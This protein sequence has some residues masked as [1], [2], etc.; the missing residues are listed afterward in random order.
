V[1]ILEKM[2]GIMLAAITV[3][4]LLGQVLSDIINITLP[5]TLSSFQI[6]FSLVIPLLIIFGIVKYFKSTAE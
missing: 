3:G 4:A 2:I 1:D 5:G 6:F